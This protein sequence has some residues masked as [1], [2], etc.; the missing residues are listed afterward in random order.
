MAAFVVFEV[1]NQY[2]TTSQLVDKEAQGLERLFRLS[3]YFRDDKF[4]KKML[5]AI[6]NYADLVIT[7]K[8]RGLGNGERSAEMGKAFRKISELIRDIRFNDNH[9]SVIFHHI[10]DHYGQLGLTRTE[11]I[12]QSLTRLPI[13]LKAFLYTSSLFA[14]LTFILMPFSNMYYGF[15]ATG[16]LG[17]V[18]AMVFQLVEDLDNPFVGYWNITPE[19]FERTIR[20]IEEDY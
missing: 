12:N 2:N 5:A 17:F 4:T 8:F 7:D 10:V 16:S 13:L 15:L 14:L 19:P 18:L 1:W 6:K 11:R 3:L 20:H 9:D